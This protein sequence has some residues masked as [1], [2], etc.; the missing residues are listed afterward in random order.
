MAE[1]LRPSTR[2]DQAW[3]PTEVAATRRTGDRRRSCS[4]VP[5]PALRSPAAASPPSSRSR[6]E[7]A[8][9][10]SCG[11]RQ[12][13]RVHG[14][15]GYG[16][17]RSPRGGRGW[18]RHPLKVLGSQA[19]STPRSDRCRDLP[20]RR[21]AQAHRARRPPSSTGLDQPDST[22]APPPPRSTGAR[23]QTG[24][25]HD[26]DAT[27]TARYAPSSRSPTKA[28]AACQGPS[29]HGYT[30]DPLF[31]EQGRRCT[32]T[33]TRARHRAA[34]SVVDR[35]DGSLDDR[36]PKPGRTTFSPCGSRSP[37]PEWSRHEL[38]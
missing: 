23:G 13:L 26:L 36:T 24:H 33:R 30:S 32:A 17:G 29:R 20:T 11:A 35:H 25:A 10:A 14:P 8:C 18:R 12:V 31:K 9:R 19:S 34:D 3:L 6:T 27:R 1:P 15:W 16:R 37:R 22:N 7:A 5:P 2:V 38:S 4:G 21:P 28:T